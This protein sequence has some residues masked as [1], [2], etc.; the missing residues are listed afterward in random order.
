VGDRGDFENW[1]VEMIEKR[2][3]WLCS[4]AERCPRGWFLPDRGILESI[5][6]AHLPT[7]HADPRV[8]HG[9]AIIDTTKQYLHCRG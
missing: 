7:Q 2:V 5:Y 1:K 9:D 4:A 3:M 6:V 8:N